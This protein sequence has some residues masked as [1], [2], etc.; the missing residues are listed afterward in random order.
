MDII[1]FLD[2][3]APLLAPLIRVLNKPEFWNFFG[4]FEGI[5]ACS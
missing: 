1:S 3:K 2:E 5:E 4:R